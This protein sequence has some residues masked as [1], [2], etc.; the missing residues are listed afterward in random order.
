[1][2][3]KL[4]RACVLTSGFIASTAWAQTAQTVDLCDDV[5]EA[6]TAAIKKTQDD[7][8]R[9][10]DTMQQSRDTMRNCMLDLSKAFGSA[11]GNRSGLASIVNLLGSGMDDATCRE[12]NKRAR[13]ALDAIYDPNNAVKHLPANAIFPS[14]SSPSTFTGGS[15][16]S[17]LDDIYRKLMR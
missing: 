3:R 10:F 16:R 9:E 1:M 12:V 13:A 8:Q 7:V 17:D 6:R 2:N 11:V 15:G 4:F 14:G 5:D